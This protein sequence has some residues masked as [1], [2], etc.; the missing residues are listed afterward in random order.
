MHYQRGKDREQV[1]MTSLSSLVDFDSFARL[2]D[3]FVDALPILA[4]GFT[5][6]TLNKEGNVPYHPSDL[7]KLLLYGYRKGVRSANKLNEATRINVEVMWL[8][9]GLQPSARTINYFRSNNSKA[10]EKAHRHF[11]KLLKEWQMIDGQAVAVDGVKVRAQNSLKLNF[12]AKKIERHLEY[13]EN[14]MSDYLD[15]LEENEKAEYSARKKKEKRKSIAQ[16]QEQLKAGKAKYEQLSEELEQ[17]GEKQISKTDGDARAVIK[18]R[19]IVEVGYN[20]QAVADAK[21]C[22]VVDVFTGGV[23]DMYELSRAAKRTQEILDKKYIDMLADKGYHNGIELAMTERCGVRPFVSPKTSRPQKEKGFRKEDFSYD[24]KSDSY[25]CPAGESLQ[26]ELS[27]KKNSFKKPYKVKRYGT[28]KCQ[29][30][31][32]K[33]KCT[34]S[35]QGR[36]IERPL[37]QPYIERNNKRVTRYKDFY[38]LRAQIIEHIFGTWKRHWGMDYTLLKGKEKV[39]TEYRLA[40]LAYNLRRS[41]SILGLEELKRRLKALIFTIFSLWCILNHDGVNN[42]NTGKIKLQRV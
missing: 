37:H 17:S 5:H 29:V 36:K 23:N 19:N 8:L 22:L 15:Q 39:I 28:K 26:Q 41:L 38:R 12:N 42:N 31:P 2:V 40:A 13:I 35:K 7:F 11:V 21:N 6:S 34:T 18:H 16:K 3:L 32:M 20:I 30:C 24:A 14:K 27:Y 33:S 9:K 4:M 25:T 1:F 10:I